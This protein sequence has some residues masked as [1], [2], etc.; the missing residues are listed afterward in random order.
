MTVYHYAHPFWHAIIFFAMWLTTTVPA[1]SDVITFT[2]TDTTTDYTSIGG[3]TGHTLSISADNGGT[4]LLG[5]TWNHND[6]F[7]ANFTS[8]GYSADYTTGQFS[9]TTDA[10]GDFTQSFFN[11][12]T[13]TAGSD[14]SA[15]TGTPALDHSF[16]DFFL[17]TGSAG[18]IGLFQQTSWI[19]FDNHAGWAASAATSA[20]VPE[21]SSFVFLA[22]IVAGTVG[23]HH[24]R[25]RRI[26]AA[27]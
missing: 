11:L 12:L 14:S 18:E 5:Q 24:R 6:T 27:T 4:G 13:G 1:V 15:G 17:F 3:G 7:T 25:R 22:T 8:G 20:A 26:A 19:A 2:H 9:F 10:G 16:T 21:P 23:F